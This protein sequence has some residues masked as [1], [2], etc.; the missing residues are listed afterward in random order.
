MQRVVT[1]AHQSNYPNPI[2]FQSGETV[3]LGRTD[4]EFPGWIRARLANGNEGWAP[5][6]LFGLSCR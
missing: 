3:T 2:S 5:E 1:E 6:E 4:S